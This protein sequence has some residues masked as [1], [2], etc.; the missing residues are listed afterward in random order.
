MR[1]TIVR[2]VTMIGAAL[3]V[4]VALS[5]CGGGGD[6]MTL[7]EY[8][9]ALEEADTK[10]SQETDAVFE[11][12]T[13]PEDV[14]AIRDAFSG[15]PDVVDEFV[16]ELDDINPPDEA[17]DAHERAVDAGNAF[18]DVL[19]DTVGE[20]GD[21]ETAEELFAA[22]ESEA[23]TEADDAFESAC[24]DLLAVAEENNISVSLNCQSDD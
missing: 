24:L 17:E 21:A 16:N 9:A 7:E 6:S 8:F 2:A 5:A 4:M 10:F 3:A 13:D 11:G 22:T 1:N 12:V 20:V 23:F 15:L 18:V 19:R 14:D